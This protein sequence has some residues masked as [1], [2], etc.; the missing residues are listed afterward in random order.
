MLSELW[1]IINEEKSVEDKLDLLTSIGIT[2]RNDELFKHCEQIRSEI[3]EQSERG[4]IHPNQ[5]QGLPVDSG[6]E[7]SRAS[8][9]RVPVVQEKG[10]LREWDLSTLGPL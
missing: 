7:I 9:L 10:E 5:T 1:V 8:V 2:T 4:D 3:V 6:G